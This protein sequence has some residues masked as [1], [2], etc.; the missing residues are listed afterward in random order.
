MPF[1]LAADGSASF[2]TDASCVLVQVP[3]E[4]GRENKAE[5]PDLFIT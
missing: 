1:H 5:N 2:A 4:R 3:G